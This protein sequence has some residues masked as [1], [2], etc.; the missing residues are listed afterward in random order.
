MDFVEVMEIEDGLIRHH[1]VY[2]GWFGVRVMERDE[3]H[4]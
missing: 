4:R 1:R 2:W 3:Y